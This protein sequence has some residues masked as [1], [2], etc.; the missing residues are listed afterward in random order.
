[1]VDG[2]FCTVG[3]ANLNSRSLRFDYEDNAVII[4]PSTTRQLCDM[5]ERDKAKSFRLTEETWDQFRTRWQKTRGWFAH[6]LSS[7]L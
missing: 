6:L 7:W 3:S 2:K 4:D 5:F 1:M